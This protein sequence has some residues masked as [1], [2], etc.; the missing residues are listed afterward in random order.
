MKP[1]FHL[2]LAIVTVLGVLVQGEVAP[3]RLSAGDESRVDYVRDVKPIFIEHCSSCHG[4]L[5]QSG[6]LR[7]DT[8][9]AMLRGGDSG[10]TVVP[11]KAER[12]PHKRK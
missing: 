2:K 4:G 7:L 3:R 10:A 1:S 11:G 6:G 8:A 9:A 12:C 5:K